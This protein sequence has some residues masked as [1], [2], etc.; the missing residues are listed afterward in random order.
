MNARQGSWISARITSAENLLTFIIHEC[1]SISNAFDSTAGRPTEAQ[2][3]HRN[4]FI[5]EIHHASRIS[6]RRFSCPANSPNVSGMWAPHKCILNIALPC[7]ARSTSGYVECEMHVAVSVSPRL[8]HQ[9]YAFAD[10]EQ[11]MERQ[12]DSS[13][14][15]TGES[16]LIYWWAKL[17]FLFMKYGADKCILFTECNRIHIFVQLHSRST[18]V[19]STFRCSFAF[20]RF[21]PNEVDII[22]DILCTSMCVRRLLKRTIYADCKTELFSHR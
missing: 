9:A 15:A 17:N 12:L 19:H 13:T 6:R 3:W 2:R 7:I 10:G 21:V 1:I 20:C 18:R 22:F 16:N 8:I 5:C 11:L 14:K 4:N